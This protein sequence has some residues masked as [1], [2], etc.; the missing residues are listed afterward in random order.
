MRDSVRPVTVHKNVVLFCRGHMQKFFSVLG[1][2]L[3]AGLVGLARQRGEPGQKPMTEQQIKQAQEIDRMRAALG[4]IDAQMDAMT[5]E[6]FL[7]CMNS[8]GSRDFCGC[9]RE[10]SPVGADFALYV[11]ITSAPSRDSLG[12]PKLSVEEKELVD[13]SIK[14]RDVCVARA[15][16][17]GVK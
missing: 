12:Y 10:E 16:P 2:I 3:V 14:A 17:P 11:R 6:K 4:A 15:F 5:A 8:I 7:H 9:I 1:L 13:N